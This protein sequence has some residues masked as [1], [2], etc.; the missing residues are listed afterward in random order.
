MERLARFFWG[1][2]PWM[3]ETAAVLSGVVQH[4]ADFTIIVIMLLLNAGVGFWQEFK[5][6]TAIA[7]LK[8]RLALM[9]RVLRDGRWQNLPARDLVRGDVVLIRLGNIVPAD[10]QIPR[11]G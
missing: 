8:Q 4:W 1:P 9:A 2:I 11:P 7:A 10:V 5:A 6:D 3:I